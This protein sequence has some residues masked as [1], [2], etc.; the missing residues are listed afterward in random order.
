MPPEC[1]DPIIS[2]SAGRFRMNRPGSDLRRLREDM[3]LTTRDVEAASTALVRKYQNHKYAVP[4][5]RLC[6]FETRGMIP[7]IYRLHSL[8]VIYRQDFDQLLRLY[9]VGMDSS[10]SDVQTGSSVVPRHYSSVIAASSVDGIPQRSAFNSRKTVYLGQITQH[11]TEAFSLAYLQ[12]F[13]NSGSTYGYIGSEDWTM[14]PLL[15]P[16]SLVQIDESRNRVSDGRWASEYERPIYFVETRE[17]PV[18]C[19]CTRS[20]AGLILTPHPLSPVQPRILQHHDAEVLGQVVGAALM[21]RGPHFVP[22][23]SAAPK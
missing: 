17:R 7:S 15:P 21:F 6:E 13:A 3:G 16:T 14:Y 22:G 8:S 20:R 5:S 19:W 11:L 23:Q 18:C 9:G 1:K 12:Q 10:V 4:I 2:N